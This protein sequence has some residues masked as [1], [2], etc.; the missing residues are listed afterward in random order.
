MHVMVLLLQFKKKKNRFLDS[1]LMSS[2][3][4]FTGNL[5]GCKTGFVN[6]FNRTEVL[7]VFTESI[8]SLLFLSAHSAVVCLS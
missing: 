4:G 6:A 3:T 2:F 8:V 7:R 5:I 1:G